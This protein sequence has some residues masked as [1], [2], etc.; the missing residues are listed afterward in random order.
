M[1]LNFDVPAASRACTKDEFTK[2]ESEFDVFTR[3]DVKGEIILDTGGWDP[4]E[5]PLQALA[6]ILGEDAGDLM[7][8]YLV[9]YVEG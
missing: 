9:L 2:I 7:G 5:N 8:L 4:K 1:S 6:G 3:D